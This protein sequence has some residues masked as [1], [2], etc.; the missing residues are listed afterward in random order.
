M[1]GA[2][3]I[4]FQTI[5]EQIVYCH[6]KQKLAACTPVTKKC[7]NKM[8]ISQAASRSFRTGSSWKLKQILIMHATLRPRGNEIKE[9]KA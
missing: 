9:K 3:C 6:E 5:C 7:L 8:S 2:K 1:Q 4:I